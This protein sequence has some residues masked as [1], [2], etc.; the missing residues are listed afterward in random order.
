[1]LKF[2]LILGLF[3]YT[4]YKVGGFIMRALY[5]ASGRQ[6]YQQRQQQYSKNNTTNGRY[7]EIKVDYVPEDELKKRRSSSTKK[8]GEYVDFEEVE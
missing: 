7:G 1:M 6:Q 3:F 5:G 2:L 8:G 4:F